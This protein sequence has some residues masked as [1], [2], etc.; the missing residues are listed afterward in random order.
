MNIRTAT[1]ADL[2]NIAALHIQSWRD[3]Y[4][5]ILPASFLGTP[6]EQEFT[7]LWRDIDIEARDVVLVAKNKGLYGF[8]AVWC[9][10]TPYID[11]LHVKPPLRSKNIGTALMRSAA[12][13]LL[14][15]EHKTAYLWVF[16]RNPKAIRFYERMGG[17][18]TEKASQ[19]IFGY[20]IPSLKIEWSDLATVLN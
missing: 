6:L 2:P 1:K 3:A 9:R 5:G 16:E 15:R 10:P 8:I 11:N 19:D 14:V 17:I 20:N 13:E 18:I 7:R 4:E 12:E